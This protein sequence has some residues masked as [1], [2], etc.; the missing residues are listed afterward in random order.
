MRNSTPQETV[1]LLLEA[2]SSKPGD[3]LRS[4]FL[5]GKPGAPDWD[6]RMGAEVYFNPNKL[7]RAAS[8]V[9]QK[10][11]HHLRQLAVNDISNILQDFIVKN[12][13][14]LAEDVFFLSNP[15]SYSEQVRPT[16]VLTLSAVLKQ[17]KIFQPESHLTLFPLIPVKVRADF[18][19][20]SYFLISPNSLND[21]FLPT[22]IDARYIVPDQFPPIR[23]W[24]GVKNKPSCWLGVHSP[25][26]QTAAKTKSAI[27]GALALTPPP[28]YRHMFS[29]R[30]MFGGHC[31]ITDRATMKF[32]D[33]HTPPLMHDIEIAVDDHAWLKILATK[34][35]SDD[36]MTRRQIKALEYFYRAWDQKPSERFPTL[37]MTL[38]AIFGDAG[39]ATQSVIDGVRNVL[40]P[41]VRHERLSLLMKLRGSVIHGGAPDVYESRKYAKYYD[42]YEAD[43]IHDL[44][45]V[46]A[47]CLRKVIFRDALKEHADPDSELIAEARMK[48]MIP[49]AFEKKSILDDT[50]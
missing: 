16:T 4:A 39:G 8:F 37:C 30:K 22:S 43:P 21:G 33:I 32:E 28:Q 42:T 40:G 6:K 18:Q 17:S 47:K 13:W 29:G 19:A 35:V 49:E 34:L 45:L 50:V 46:A 14:Y 1:Q 12:F 20:S 3:G 27:L 24:E 41:H 23:D 10:G 2:M 31:S 48:G 7:M 38:D 11:P 44:E 5:F 15:G 36:K 26:I 9:R 25:V